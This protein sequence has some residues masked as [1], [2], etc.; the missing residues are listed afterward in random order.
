MK[1][2]IFAGCVAVLSATI[3]HADILAQTATGTVTLQ[4]TPK[5]AAVFDI[6]A[7]DTLTALGV[8]V[9]GVPSKLYVDYLEPVAQSAAIVGTLFE[10]DYEK[11]AILAPDLIVVGSRTSELV[12]PLSRIAPVIDMTIS[13]TD[14]LA[15]T[16]DRIAAFGAV[17]GKKERA[18][19][20]AAEL[21]DKITEVR[22]TLQGK[23]DALIILTNGNKISAFGQGSRF[24]WLHADLGLPMAASDLEAKN[25]GQAISFE[26]IAETDPDWLIVIDRGAAIGQQG[27][28]Q[29]TLDN[30]LVANTKAA[31]SGRIVYLSSAPVYVAGGGASSVMRT[32][33]ELAEAF[34]G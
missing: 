25:H 2:A 27:A 13:G 19:R 29:A 7:I 10:P 5:S 8:E 26:F 15:Q 23:G 24:G 33:D 28:A 3:G 11:L 22:N 1:H 12:D 18:A 21:E 20:L 14:I 32:L 17:F 9:A 6:A 30:S 31:K 34:G 16:R 4:T